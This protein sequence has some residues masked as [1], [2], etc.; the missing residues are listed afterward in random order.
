MGHTGIVGGA[1]RYS[2]GGGGGGGAHR[3]SAMGRH[4]GI[5]RRT[6]GVNIGRGFGP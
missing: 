6:R 1:H 2:G 5:Q 3:Y 4:T